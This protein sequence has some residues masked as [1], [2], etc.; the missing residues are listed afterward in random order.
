MLADRA[1]STTYTYG[2]DRTEDGYQTATSTSTSASSTSTLPPDS[3]ISD[4]DDK[5][6]DTALKVGLGV[7]ISVGCL[8]LGV[9]VGWFIWRKRKAAVTAAASPKNE[10]AQ[11]GA[12]G[13]GYGGGY[14]N[15]N[16]AH[17]NSM[18]TPHSMATSH[19]MPTPN[20]MPIHNGAPMYNGM[21]APNNMPIQEYYA[22]PN[23]HPQHVS[24][25]DS[26]EPRSELP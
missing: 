15:N 7:G 4:I 13:G 22:K 5:P 12:Y 17:A 6:D 1:P 21:P 25:L 23:Q 19:S 26:G 11:N 14:G 16:M 3:Q 20:G 10:I 8:L 2:P 24:E 18:H 9:L